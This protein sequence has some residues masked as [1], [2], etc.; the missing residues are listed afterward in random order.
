M[1]YWV[2]DPELDA[3]RIYR[4]GSAG[5]ERAVELAREAG[6]LLTTTLLPGL[7]LPLADIFKD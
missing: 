2:V 1:E 5:Y 6:E 3:V 7:T 4:L